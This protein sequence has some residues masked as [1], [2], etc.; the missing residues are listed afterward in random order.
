[1]AGRCFMDKARGVERCKGCGGPGYHEIVEP[2]KWRYICLRCQYQGRV[3]EN[4]LAALALWNQEQ[5]A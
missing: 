3:A 5:R 4:S 2:G 1:M